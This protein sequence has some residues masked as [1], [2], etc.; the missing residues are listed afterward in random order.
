MSR[1]AP[2]G[3]ASSAEIR[4][5]RFADWRALREWAVGEAGRTG[6]GKKT[7]RLHLLAPGAGAVWVLER[8]LRERLPEAEAAAF[9]EVGEAEAVFRDLAGD[10]DPPFR[11]ASPLTR[12]VLMEEALLAGAKEEGAPAGDP[13][14][15]A[16]ALLAFVDEQAGDRRI[17]PSRAAFAALADRA[18]RRLGETLETDEG[19]A[20]LLSLTDW[21]S[22]VVIRYGESL[23][24]AG[25]VDADSLRRRLLA[26]AAEFAP[27]FR[28][29][30]VLALGEDALRPADAQLLA[31][32]LPPG[33]L[34]WGLVEGA[35]A[36]PLP[37][38]LAIRDAGAAA[39]EQPTLF[40]APAGQSGV[41]TR[42]ATREEDAS[43]LRPEGEEGAPVFRTTDR[44][45]EV[46]LAAHLLDQFSETAGGAFRG[47]C[48]CALA[49][50]NPGTYLGIADAVF[51]GPGLRLASG[52]QPPLSA[53]PWVASLADVL[54]FA[55]RPGR[56]SLG[57]ALLRSPFFHDP[58]LPESARA[59]D[60]LEEE[61]PACRI[62]DTNDPE[63]LNELAGRLRQAADRRRKGSDRRPARRDDRDEPAHR[64]ERA[65]GE[66]AEAEEKAE[67]RRA[68]LAQAETA[69]A[70][71]ERLHAYAHALAPLRQPDAR[72]GD[73][74]EA[75]RQFAGDHLPLPHE[76]SDDREDREVRMAALSALEQAE[77]AAPSEAR[78]G[79]AARFH[80]RIRRILLRR[81]S[82][83]RP[84][85]GTGANGGGPHLI[86]AADAPYGDYDC[87]VLLGMMDADWPGPRPGNI[88]FP[89]ALLEPATRDRHNRQRAREIH[90]LRAFPGLPRSRAAFTRP[91]LDDGFPAGVS[92]LEAELT[93][94]ARA[95]KRA[96]IPEAGVAVVSP[97]PPPPLPERLE[98]RA[99]SAGVLRQPVSPSGLD[100]YAE[101]PA[102]FFA[103]YVLGLKE[104][105]PLADIPPATERGNLLHDFLERVFRRLAGAGPVIGASTL[106][107]ALALFRKEFRAFTHEHAM[108]P[109][110][111]RGFERWLFGGDAT[112]AALLWLLREEAG[113][114]PSRPVQF[115]AWIEGEVE[116]A[117]AGTPALRVRGKLD[118]LDELLPDGS[119]RIVEFKSGRYYDNPPRKPLQPRLYA[120]LVEARDGRKTGFGIPYFGN[121][122][123]IGPGDKPTEGEQDRQIRGIRDGLARGEF[124]PPESKDG[125]FDFDLV[126]RRDLPEKEA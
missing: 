38:W 118:R 33:A 48:R 25:R 37:P 47:Y 105:R 40:S 56:L 59:A 24:A 5:R 113:R 63:R 14:Q 96:E 98:R 97:E 122:R 30:R 32:L 87:I 75:L 77:A 49:A 109:A 76:K 119:R 108:D 7:E 91:G 12:E 82:P 26:H 44:E 94:A 31:A 3:P 123:W 95:G 8:M 18:R 107:D 70:V 23:E 54:A 53:E 72:F 22:R 68:R 66:R 39:R 52:L 62:R 106:E 120:R 92:P 111:R 78:T 79:G 115:E 20:R 93:D 21:L 6:S 61:A 116:P 64:D 73:A 74:V 69:A 13:G 4:I 85:L 110:E 88:F 101:S 43:V 57:L 29:S 9:P 51:G 112:P 55:E 2:A 45:G 10:L 36:P 67:R 121:R 35:P 80:K 83:P 27:R 58:D 89:H 86:A 125:L 126:V 114:G 46:R 11:I 71:L 1:A 60:L 100:T 42:G 34:E 117:A 65:E 81:S 50:R 28:R 84:K 104:E 103:R 102:Q 19:A 15:L 17:D 90:L 99:P 41:P 16:D 124:P